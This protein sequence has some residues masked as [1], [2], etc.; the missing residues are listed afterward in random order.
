MFALV[1]ALTRWISLSAQDPVTRSLV[2]GEI[3][4]QAVDPAPRSAGTRTFLDNLRILLG[5]RR[6]AGQDLES[7]LSGGAVEVITYRM[8]DPKPTAVGLRVGLDTASRLE[9]RGLIGPPPYVLGQASPPERGGF[10]HALFRQVDGTS[11][12]GSWTLA[13]PTVDLPLVTLVLERLSTGTGS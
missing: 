12:S 9:I 2:D 1:G 7:V 4:E 3:V 10:K 5:R 6:T 8:T 11:A 13:V